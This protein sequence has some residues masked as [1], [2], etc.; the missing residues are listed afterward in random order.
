MP[1]KTEDL[2]ITA[3]A[4][5]VQAKKSIVALKKLSGGHPSGHLHAGEDTREEEYKGHRIVIKT[6]Y[7]VKVDGKKF[8][9]PLGVM[10]NGNVNYHGIPNVSFAS[11]MDLMKGVIDQFPSEF[12]KKKSKGTDCEQEHDHNHGSDDCAM[13]EG[14]KTKTKKTPSKSPVEQGGH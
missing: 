4:S 8:N 11:A 5:L 7:E 10:Y 2:E 1:T 6:T 3:D 12:M 13:H 9:A 14:S